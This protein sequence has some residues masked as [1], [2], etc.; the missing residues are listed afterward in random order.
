[1]DNLLCNYDKY[2]TNVG[3]DIAK[4]LDTGM[5]NNDNSSWNNWLKQYNYDTNPETKYNYAINIAKKLTGG[6]RKKTDKKK[7]KGRKKTSKKLKD[8]KKTTK[9]LQKN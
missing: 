4:R 6:G 2:L 3:T 5:L 7:L 9:Q 8:R 1:M